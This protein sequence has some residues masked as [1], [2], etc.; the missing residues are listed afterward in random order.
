LRFRE[1]KSGCSKYDIRVANILIGAYAKL[2]IREKAEELKERARM[3]VP[4]LMQNP[5]KYFWITICK[6]ETLSW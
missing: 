2:D 4:S 3:R 6:R 1:W 5:G